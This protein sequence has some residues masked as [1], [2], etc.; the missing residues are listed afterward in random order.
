MIGFRFGQVLPRLARENVANL[1]RFIAAGYQLAGMESK[2]LSLDGAVRYFL[3]SLSGHVEDG[4]L[5]RIWATKQD[6]TR[7]KT[8]EEE[9]RVLNNE[10]E[11][12]VKQRTAQLEAANRELESFA[13][14]VSHDLRAPLRAIDGYTKILL[15]D[16]AP[17]LDDEGRRVCSVISGGARTMG[18][19]IEDLLS[20]SRV[21]RVEMQ[22][23]T[24][25]MG[26]L[27]HR[28]FNELTTPGDRQRI[29]FRVA[30]LPPAQ[31]DPSLLRQVWANLVGNAVKFSSGRERAVIEVSAE[32]GDNGPV[33]SIRDNGAG[34]DMRYADKLFGVFQR[35]HGA[36]EFEG[37][38]VGLAI[39]QRIV[40]RHGGRIWGEGETDRGAVFHF[41]LGEST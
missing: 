26:A 40:Q 27:A 30:S 34:F 9:I 38:G 8:A 20:F 11:Q 33:Y 19:L 41:T 31:G 35:L 37:T 39:V 6:I 4:G 36:H 25:D 15:E 21:G 5:V 17:L 2:E 3:N 29:D 16:Y 13:Y 7:I 12:R 22:S 10:L 28:A 18:R 23:L 32:T 1:R 14:T 24:V